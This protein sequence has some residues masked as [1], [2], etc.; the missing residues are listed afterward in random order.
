VIREFSVVFRELSCDIVTTRL[1]VIDAEEVFSS[2]VLL[3]LFCRDVVREVSVVDE[4]LVTAKV[5]VTN[6]RKK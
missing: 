2:V 4:G 3:E 1:L 6:I 5:V